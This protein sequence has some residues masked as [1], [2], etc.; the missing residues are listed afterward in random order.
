MGDL[1]EMCELL[2]K[3]KADLE[4]KLGNVRGVSIITAFFI[5]IILNKNMKNINILLKLNYLESSERKKALFLL[6][7]L[8]CYNKLMKFSQR[9]QSYNI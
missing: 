4:R 2:K 1:K 6:V 9:E 3:E 8:K 5:N 7:L